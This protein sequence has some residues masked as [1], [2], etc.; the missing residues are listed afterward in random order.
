MKEQLY[1]TDSHAHVHGREFAADFAPMLERAAQAGVG[2]IITVGADPESSREAVELANR[3]E[4]IYC[5]VGVHPHDAERV[6]DKCYDIIRALAI[7]N[8]KVIAIGEIGLDFYRDRS[9]REVQEQV[10]RR[11]IHLAR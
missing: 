7:E 3:C 8:P 2:T 9:P 1:L 5:A 6:T 10:F 11:F 4:Q